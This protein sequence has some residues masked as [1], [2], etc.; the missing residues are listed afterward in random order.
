[1]RLRDEDLLAVSKKQVPP[2]NTEHA[3]SSKEAQKAERERSKR[4]Q[5]KQGQRLDVEF[6]T[7]GKLLL[8]LW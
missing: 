2:E 7:H 3:P 5:R 6:G 8:H 4:S 1:M